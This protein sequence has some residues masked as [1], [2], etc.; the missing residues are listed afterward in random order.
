M[1]AG[2]PVQAIAIL[3]TALLFDSCLLSLEELD[4]EF[5]VTAKDQILE[6]NETFC[7]C[8]TMAVV[9][10]EAETAFAI[11][12]Q[13]D[14]SISGDISWEG[15]TLVFHPLTELLPGRRYTISV[16]GNIGISDGRY[17]DLDKIMPFY[18]ESKD[19]PAVLYKYQPVAGARIGS[20]DTLSFTFNRAINEDSFLENF[21]LSPETEFT[22]QLSADSLTITI[23]PKTFWDNLELYSW[24]LKNNY[25][26]SLGLVLTTGY[27]GSFIVIEDTDPPELAG[28]A[29][30][31]NINI[32]AP[33]PF[34]QRIQGPCGPLDNMV[35]YNDGILFT[36]SEAVI[37]DLMNSPVSFSPAI[38][39]TWYGIDTANF[40]FVPVYGW[41][42]A[43][44]YTITVNDELTDIYNNIFYLDEQIAFTPNIPILEVTAIHIGTLDLNP[45]DYACDNPFDLS[46]VESVTEPGEYYQNFEFIFS[47]SFDTPEERAAVVDMLKF[48][49]LFGVSEDSE[50]IGIELIEWDALNMAV[51]ITWTGMKGTPANEQI[52]YELRVSGNDSGLRTADGSFLNEGINLLLH[53][54]P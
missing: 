11:R 8:F 43:R 19:G 23:I 9:K 20:A 7:A 14:K 34:E 13:Y 27:D 10:Q 48:A 44:E 15:N 2:R 45:M 6:V 32:G 26:D 53:W 3:F 12:D 42:M 47:E 28:L 18:A 51:T 40:L 46:L 41:T 38:S 35:E 37:F 21:S 52:Y 36:F 30:V 31:F 33:T 4:V 50:Y 29:A 39:G 49:R 1:S 54:V 17:F 24:K 5:N 22:H 25:T 16:R